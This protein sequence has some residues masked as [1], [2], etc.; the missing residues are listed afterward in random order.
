MAMFRFLQQAIRTATLPPSRNADSPSGL[1][2]AGATLVVFL[3]AVLL[4]GL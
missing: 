1:A 4:F 2:F 3:C